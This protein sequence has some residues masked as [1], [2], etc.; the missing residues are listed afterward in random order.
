MKD[1]M[2]KQTIPKHPLAEVFVFAV[3]D[4]SVSANR[5]RKKRTCPYHTRV[6]HCT[7]DKA[8]D[9]LGVCSVLHEGQVV[10]TC[11][12][13]FRQNWLIADDAADFFFAPDANWTTLTEIRLKD[14]DG[15]SAG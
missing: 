7:Q 5:H 15:G 6:P 1:R 10:I 13:R 9:P 11:P 8:Q 3:A 14:G 2:A 4:M 12:I